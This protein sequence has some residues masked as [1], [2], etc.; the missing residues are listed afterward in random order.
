MTN[1][2][3]LLLSAVLGASAESAPAPPSIV[4][5]SVTGVS[6]IEGVVSLDAGSRHGLALGDA[7]AILDG[8]RVLSFGHIFVIDEDQSA[9]RLATDTPPNESWVSRRAVVVPA[10]SLSAAK[11]RLPARTT[12]RARV[13]DLGPGGRQLWIDAGKASGL[14]PDDALWILRDDFPLARGRV[15]LALERAAL[16]QIRPLVANALPDSGDEVELWPSPA[17]IR[18]DRAE[19]V[20]MAVTPNADGAQLT[21]AGSLREGFKPERQVEVFDGEA[22]VGLAAVTAASDRLCVAQALQA[23]CTTQPA[24]GQRAVL[25]PEPGSAD[26]R[27]E[28]RVFDV[29][30]GYA[31]LSAGDR[32]GVRI[33]Q[34]F[35]VVRDGQ[36][37]ARLAVKAVK[38]DFAG[39]E[40]VLEADG[41]APD[42]RKWDRAVREPVPAAAVQRLGVVET[43]ARGSQWMT[44]RLDAPAARPDVG[45]VLRIAVE[46]PAAAVVVA[47]FDPRMIL[48]VPPGWGAATIPPDVPVERTTD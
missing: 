24:R 32:D 37:V 25:R 16:A 9:A 4:R 19:S 34:I 23:F 44:A 30:P 29:R 14:S 28:A 48:Y 12:V 2:L 41:S 38:D 3:C 15:V 11:G 33:D 43:V 27:L 31:L 42:V 18:S 36:I 39:A 47:V 8:G 6:R 46:P 20:V 40:P 35:A 10:S 17:M 26:R 22:Y 45:E 7:M 1:G 21:L 13:A 5:A